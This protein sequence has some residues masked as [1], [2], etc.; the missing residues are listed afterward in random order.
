MRMLIVLSLWLIPSSLALAQPDEPVPKPEGSAPQPVVD[1]SAKPATD[2]PPPAHAEIAPAPVQPVAASSWD[3]HHGVTVEFD[4]AIAA[5][6]TPGT[7]YG[8]VMVH[9]FRDRNAVSGTP[10][11]ADMAL[12]GAALGVGGW[13]NPRL[14]V[15][16]RLTT[17]PVD[18]GQSG[19][20]GTGFIGFLGPSAQYWINEHFWLGGGA[21]LATFRLLG[22]ECTGGMPTC[23]VNGIG[24]DARAGYAFGTGK[25]NLHVSLEAMPGVFSV[26]DLVQV[27]VTGLALFAGYQ[28]L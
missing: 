16:G 27:R 11:D 26:N 2:A 24:L 17:V 4:L 7:E 28:F 6:R 3:H 13:I 21:G 20:T 12:A 5:M 10:G 18:L 25:H 14:A 1:A 9:F 8:L 15:T 19:A 22:A 23:G